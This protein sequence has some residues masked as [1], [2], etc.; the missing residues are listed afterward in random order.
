MNRPP[1]ASLSE[2]GKRNLHGARSGNTGK[3]IEK[4]PL[5]GV[6][7]FR[8]GLNADSL[9]KA[10]DIRSLKHIDS[11]RQQ[12]L[13]ASQKWNAAVADFD[14]SKQVQSMNKPVLPGPGDVGFGCL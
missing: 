8:S 7:L 9:I 12:A 1:P 14:A 2:R 11:V 6:D 10:L 4:T 13:A 5:T 3:S